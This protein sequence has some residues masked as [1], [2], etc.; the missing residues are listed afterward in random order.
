MSLVYDVGMHDGE[1]TAFYLHQGHSVVA[2]E[3]IA[4]LVEVARSRFATEASEGRFVPVNVAIGPERGMR[5]FWV[6]DSVTIWSS[7]DERIASRGHR[8][9]RRIDVF[10]CPFEEVLARYGTPTY[11]KVDIEGSDHL[12][13]KG[14]SRPPDYVS[15]EC[16]CGGSEVPLTEDEY[17]YNLRLLREIGYRR[18][19]LVHQESFVPIRADNLR[20]A[21]DACYR[22]RV[23]SEI[24]ARAAWTFAPGASGPWGEDVPGRWMEFEE[25]L[26]VYGESRRLH[27][28]APDA[29]LYS[30]WFDWHAKARP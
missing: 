3:A 25:A 17:L 23:K 30:F 12:C 21:C 19:K 29:E 26:D 20:D 11:L 18:F 10:T 16:E 2:I 28:S 22:D 8:R 7:R 6:C 15:V 4:E 5:P 24:E 1:D 13:L 9:H 14:L 27:F